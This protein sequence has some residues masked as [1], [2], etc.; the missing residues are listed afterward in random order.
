MQAVKS[1]VRVFHH[2]AST[3]AISL[4]THAPTATPAHVS[5]MPDLA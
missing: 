4:N 3:T 5:T 1:F 2:A